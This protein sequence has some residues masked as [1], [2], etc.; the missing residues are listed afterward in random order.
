[1]VLGRQSVSGEICLF[2]KTAALTAI[3]N[4]WEMEMD[5]GM[6][7]WQSWGEKGLMWE[8]EH[9]RLFKGC[10]LI[11]SIQTSAKSQLFLCESILEYS[12]LLDESPLPFQ[13]LELVQ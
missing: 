12:S 11:N 1:M 8:N 2:K 10:D 7:G 6:V 9:F 3:S 5:S 13:T 4:I